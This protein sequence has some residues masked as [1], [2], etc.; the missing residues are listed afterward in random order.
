PLAKLNNLYWLNLDNNQIVDT[1]PLAKLNN[2]KSL[3][4]SNNQIVDTAIKEL[5]VSLPNATIKN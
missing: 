3:N 2:L 5:Q 4:L 1:A